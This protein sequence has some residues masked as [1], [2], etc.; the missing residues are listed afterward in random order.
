MS[1]IQLNHSFQFVMP[2]INRF[3][4]DTL[5]NI[6]PAGAHYIFLVIQA[7]NRSAIHTLLQ[8]PYAV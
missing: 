8:S 5:V 7:G 4:D 3:V 6:L 1:T 2:V